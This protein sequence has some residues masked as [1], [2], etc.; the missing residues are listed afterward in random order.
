MILVF[1]FCF[2]LLQLSEK[3]YRS[4][5]D[6][7][8]KMRFTIPFPLFAYP[9]YLVSVCPCADGSWSSIDIWYWTLYVWLS[10]VMQWE[11][12]PGKK[13][14]HFDPNSDLFLPNEKKDIITSTL[15]WT[16][17]VALLVGLSCV[18]GPGLIFKLYGVPYLVGLSV[19]D[20][21]SLLV[22]GE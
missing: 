15:C 7:T 22:I 13:G 6:V 14:S 4:L 21:F 19:S 20:R 17:M 16:A 5:D 1:W 12:S 10:I 11:R 9:V 8:R 3:I 2:Y 18:F